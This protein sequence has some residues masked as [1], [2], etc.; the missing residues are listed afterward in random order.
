[1][2][3][4]SSRPIGIFDSGVGGLT[5]VRAVRALLPEED[6]VYLGDTARV[7]YGPK[8][9]DTVRRQLKEFI[10]RTGA[11]ELMVATQIFDHAARVRSYEI[12]AQVHQG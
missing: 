2:K 6:I 10:A 12:L 7:P 1:M 9:P 4:T 11:D 8:S 5:V 3:P